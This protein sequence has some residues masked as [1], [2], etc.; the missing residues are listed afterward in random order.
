MKRGPAAWGYN[1]LTLSLGD[2]IQRPGRPGWGLEKRTMD[3]VRKKITKSKEVKIEWSADSSGRT[4]QGRPWFKKG[5]FANDDYDDKKLAAR[6][7][8]LIKNLTVIR[9][10]KLLQAFYGTRRYI[11]VFTTAIYWTLSTAG[12]IQ[13]NPY[14]HFLKIHCHIIRLC[15]QI[16]SWK[17][18]YWTEC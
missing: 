15:F 11:T 18:R 2:S 5:C 8:F 6:S 4:F 10:I 9:A 7:R 13:S 16:G 1:W 14:I 17:K 12:W 3:L